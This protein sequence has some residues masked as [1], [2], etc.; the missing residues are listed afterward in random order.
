MRESLTD[1]QGSFRRLGENI[2]L[3][4]STSNRRKKVLL[5]SRKTFTNSTLVIHKVAYHVCRLILTKFELHHEKIRFLHMRKQRRRSATIQL[6]SAFTVA[7]LIVQSLYFPILHFMP[8]IPLLSKSEI[9]SFR[10]SSLVVKPNLWCTWSETLKTG[11]VFFS[12]HSSH[13][14]IKLVFALYFSL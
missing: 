5:I 14:H 2:T 1:T 13:I 3:G 12:S 6:I 8:P 7:A 4:N 10:P 9:S 11:F